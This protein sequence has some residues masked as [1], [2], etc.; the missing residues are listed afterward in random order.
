MISATP[1]LSQSLPGGQY[2]DYEPRRNAENSDPLALI[3]VRYKHI[4]NND[5]SMNDLGLK[6]GIYATKNLLIGAHYY[7]LFDRSVVF[8]PV[9]DD[10]K[11]A[12]KFDY[13]GGNID[14][15]I[16]E[17]RFLPISVGIN[18]GFGKL[19][20]SE[21]AG[22]PINSDLA[23]D[24]VT[25]IEPEM[26]LYYHIMPKMLISFNLGYRSISGVDYRSLSNSDLSG[27]AGGLGLAIILY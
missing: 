24:W 15:F 14:Y 11:A 6:A 12:L 3:S 20:F 19:T 26:D 1:L 16:T 17:N 5:Y 27:L 22:A 10:F 13:Y 8:N 18:V 4:V 21:F 23:G 9:S 25:V 7:Y 2:E